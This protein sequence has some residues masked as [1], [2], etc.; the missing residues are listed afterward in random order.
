MAFESQMAV[1]REKSA[2]RIALRQNVLML[3]M[4]ERTRANKKENTLNVRVP[5]ELL[6]EAD[7]DSSKPIDIFY[8]HEN[9]KAMLANSLGGVKFVVKPGS[10]ASNAFT[11]S[12]GFTPDFG[13]TI[14]EKH[15]I[16]PHGD[17]KGIVFDFRPRMMVEGL[18][19]LKGDEQPTRA[20]K[21]AQER[22]ALEE[23]RI[24]EQRARVGI[25][26]IPRP[27]GTAAAAPTASA[28][29]FV[30]PAPHPKDGLRVKRSFTDAQRKEAVRAHLRWMTQGEGM[31]F[32]KAAAEVGVAS[33][34]MRRWRE[35]HLKA[36]EREEKRLGASGAAQGRKRGLNGA[37]AH[38]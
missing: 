27:G 23:A 5:L 31:S 17:G 21:M 4:G 35:T 22:I 25:D 11:H 2:K 16:V 18:N 6:K 13:S 19:Q 12:K 32:D 26:F 30:K 1:Q 24:A 33:S 8:D 9:S 3:S 10:Y 38:H 29:R 37:H 15:E 7:I 34:L 20:Q 28:E 36:V 14:V